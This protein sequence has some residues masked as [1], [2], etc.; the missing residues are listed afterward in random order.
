M[1]ANGVKKYQFKT[2]NSEVKLCSLCLSKS[3][4]D[5]TLDKMKEAWL[6]GYAYDFSVD[7]NTFNIS[8]IWDIDMC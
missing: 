8:H 5:F 4:K 1:Y 7:Y 3:A 2:K 6:N